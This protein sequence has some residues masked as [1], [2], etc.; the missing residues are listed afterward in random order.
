MELDPL[1]SLAININTNR[2]AYALLLGSGISRAAEIPTGWEVTL[3]LVRQCMGRDGAEPH[4]DPEAWYI[5]RYGRAPNY[6][7][8]LEAIARHPTERHT[9]L[10]PYFEPTPEERDAGKKVP[11]RA[12]HAIASLVKSGFVRV[13][14]TTNFDRLLEDA[15]REAG[16]VPSVVSN[17]DQL[18]GALPIVHQSCLIVKLHGDYLDTRILNT[19]D[20]LDSYDDKWACYLDRILDEFG[21]IVCGWSGEWD[22]GLKGAIERCTTRRFTTYWACRGKPRPVAESIIAFRRAVAI[23]IKDAD[24]FFQSLDDRVQAI[25]ASHRNHPISVDAAV[26]QTK[27]M[28]ADPKR[29]IELRDFMLDLSHDTTSAIREVA[30]EFFADD[31]N[32]RSYQVLYSNLFDACDII[33]AVLIAACIHADNN[34]LAPFVDALGRVTTSLCD[35]DGRLEEYYDIPQVVGLFCL[36]AICLAGKLTS[37]ETRAATFLSRTMATSYGDQESA[38]QLIDWAEIKRRFVPPSPMGRKRRRIPFAFNEFVA[39]KLRPELSRYSRDFLSFENAFDEVECLLCLLVYDSQMTTAAE[40]PKTEP[41]FVGRF[42]TTRRK[43]HKFDAI[44]A[45][46]T[47][48]RAAPDTWPYLYAGLFRGE[49]NRFIPL[50][51]YFVRNAKLAV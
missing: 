32:S 21:L 42:M 40:D 13:I 50:T 38:V 11:T 47:K 6:S 46:K 14:L 34:Q 48:A 37:K 15:L 4:Q 45:L 30:V 1:L 5:G 39:E 22:Q 43:N 27:R 23:D 9:I 36:Y 20:E 24:Q 17:S 12:H 2:G 31:P 41:A 28:L 29:A 16:V 3:D 51:E 8:V 19:S 26:A 7:V 10:R 35:E 33:R 18:Q 25:Q 44:E 49:I